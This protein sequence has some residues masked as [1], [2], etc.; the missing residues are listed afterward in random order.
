MLANNSTIRTLKSM[1]NKNND[2]PQYEDTYYLIPRYI[3]KLPG[4]TLALIDVYETIFQF[5]NKRL[6]CYLSEK[7]LC[8]RTGHKRRHVYKALSYFEKHGELIRQRKGGKRYLICPQKSLETDCEPIEATCATAHISTNVIP[9]CTAVHYNVHHGARSTCTT[10]HF[11]S[12]LPLYEYKEKEL[13]VGIQKPTQAQ[14][15]SL[16]LKSEECLDIFES[17][18]K[19]LDVTIEEILEDCVWYYALLAKPIMVSKSIFKKWLKR[20][21]PSNYAKKE[22]NKAIKIFRD[23]SEEEKILIADYNHRIK[24]PDLTKHWKP[25]SDRQIENAEKIINFLKSSRSIKHI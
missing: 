9:K 24:N 17:K 21:N 25:L 1:T 15:N 16:C 3:R 8:E 11:S 14:L 6:P 2:K 12:A 19:S 20:E 10:V 5:W 18:F 7:A 23:L 22:K 13:C 4:I